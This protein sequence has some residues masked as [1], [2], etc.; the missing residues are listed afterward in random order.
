MKETVKPG[1]LAQVAAW[2][3]SGKA[4][5]AWGGTTVSHNM[6]EHPS[7]LYVTRFA[8]PKTDDGKPRTMYQVTVPSGQYAQLNAEQWKALVQVCATIAKMDGVSLTPKDDA[9]RWPNARAGIYDS[10]KDLVDS[11]DGMLEDLLA[12]APQSWDG[13]D[14]AEHIAVAYVRHLEQHIDK[15]CDPAERNKPGHWSSTD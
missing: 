13:D 3:W 2:S 4:E 5:A 12:N 7:G 9:E 14:A 6:L 10:V 1:W 8:G 11:H 15:C